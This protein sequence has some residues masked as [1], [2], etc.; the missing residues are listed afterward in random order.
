MLPC[1]SSQD[2]AV[3][4]SYPGMPAEPT[5]MIRSRPASSTLMTWSTVDMIRVSP[6]LSAR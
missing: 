6:P 1:R 2:Q 5:R 3:R 4:Y